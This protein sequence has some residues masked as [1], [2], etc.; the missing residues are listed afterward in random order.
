MADQQE[1]ALPTAGGSQERA[2]PSAARQLLPEM[3]PRHP[4]PLWYQHQ[5]GE[6]EEG[7]EMMLLC[8]F[9]KDVFAQCRGGRKSNPHL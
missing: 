6:E 4:N 8:C 7:E 5:V 3:L 2:L 9:Y 1:P